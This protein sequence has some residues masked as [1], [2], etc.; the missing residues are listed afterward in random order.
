MFHYGGA[1]YSINERK[2]KTIKKIA[3]Q[4]LV[5]N[6]SLYSENFNYRFDLIS[7]FENKIEWLEDIFR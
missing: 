6:P 7:I 4:F 2:K 3:S 1:L 5:T